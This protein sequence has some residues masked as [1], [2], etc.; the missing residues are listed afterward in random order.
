MLNCSLYAI[1]CCLLQQRLIFIWGCLI[2]GALIVEGTCL[3]VI[4]QYSG[5]TITWISLIYGGIR[6]SCERKEYCVAILLE[7][8][9]IF[10]QVLGVHGVDLVFL[11]NWFLRNWLQLLVDEYAQLTSF[12]GITAD[13]MW[14]FNK[15]WHLNCGVVA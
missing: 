7:Y 8:L 13:V 9:I 3:R 6:Y 1:L 15:F 2:L 14:V 4:I 10:P 5:S 11:F 12:L